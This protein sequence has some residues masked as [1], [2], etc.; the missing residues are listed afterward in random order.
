VVDLDPATEHLMSMASQVLSGGQLT[1]FMAV[2]DAT[3]Y[4]DDDGNIDVD[5]INADFRT[6][7]RLDEQPQQPGRQWGQSSGNAPGRRPGEDGHAALQKRHGVT[8]ATDQPAA[9]SRIPRGQN[10][11]DALQR[12][13]GV[14]KR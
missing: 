9:S 4:A 3:R 13:H 11:R 12:R 10:A 1:A 14:G 5:K 8:R 6:L 7:F 2:A